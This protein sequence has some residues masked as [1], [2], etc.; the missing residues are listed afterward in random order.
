MDAQELLKVT[1]S[2]Q[3]KWSSTCLLFV[4]L[5]DLSSFGS[6]FTQTMILDIIAVNSEILCL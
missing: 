1:A 6:G 2:K 3:I 4:P 5:F